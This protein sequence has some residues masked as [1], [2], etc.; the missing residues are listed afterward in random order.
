MNCCRI[1]RRVACSG[2]WNDSRRSSASG[3]AL[4]TNVL[5]PSCSPFGRGP[6]RQI[7]RKARVLSP[8]IGVRGS[9]GGGGACRVACWRL[10]RHPALTFTS[11]ATNENNSEA[12]R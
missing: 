11:L 3:S 4:A 5:H 1:A 2:Q 6:S 7:V 12:E 8:L 10:T 9:G